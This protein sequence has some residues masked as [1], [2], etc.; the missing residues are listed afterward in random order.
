MSSMYSIVAL[1]RVCSIVITER[2]RFNVGVCSI[3][4]IY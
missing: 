3:D 1:T 2:G 4:V